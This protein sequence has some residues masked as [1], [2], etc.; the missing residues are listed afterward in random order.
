MGDHDGAIMPIAGVGPTLDRM[1][2]PPAPALRVSVAPVADHE[3]AVMTVRGN[4]DIDSAPLLRDRLSA[5]MDDSEC[6][7]VLDLAGLDFCDSIGLSALADAH[8]ACSGRNGYL[9]LAAPTAFLSRILAV[10]GL[11][12]RLAIYDTVAG[13]L[14][15]EPPGGRPPASP[16]GPTR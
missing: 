1:V 10:V 13:A 4:L 11:S 5:L 3:A 2:P 8:A 15:D 16:E 9:R 12:R 14:A 6:R 7:I